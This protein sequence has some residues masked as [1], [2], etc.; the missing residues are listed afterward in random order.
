M[1]ENGAHKL[2]HSRSRKFPSEAKVEI[3]LDAVLHAVRH[4]IRI[5]SRWRSSDRSAPLLRP[6]H[7]TSGL[8]RCCHGESLISGPLALCLCQIGDAHGPGSVTWTRWRRDICFQRLALHIETVSSFSVT[9]STKE[10]IKRQIW[11]LSTN[12]SCPVVLISKSQNLFM[13]QRPQSAAVPHLSVSVALWGAI[14]IPDVLRC[15]VSHPAFLPSV[16]YGQ[17][18][19]RYFKP[20]AKTDLPHISGIRRG[21]NNGRPRLKAHHQYATVFHFT[22]PLSPLP[23]RWL[24]KKKKGN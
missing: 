14:L 3:P 19:H 24:V 13:T 21:G 20:Q 11:G 22:N 9:E 16:I 6:G 18:C 15:Q 8:M 7:N 10:N 12:K 2:R 4:L 5:A 23:S 17:T 1:E